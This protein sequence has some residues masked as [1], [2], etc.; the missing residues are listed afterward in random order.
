MITGTNE[1]TD[2]LSISP[3]TGFGIF[4]LIT[5]LEFVRNG[6]SY[7]SPTPTPEPI[8]ID[9]YSGTVCSLDASFGLWALNLGVY[10]YIHLPE[11]TGPVSLYVG[12]DGSTYYDPALIQLAQQ[13]N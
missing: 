2:T 4:S 6:S 11:I 1:V 12:L 8:R 5:N 10:V 9:I 3:L 7:D 13:A